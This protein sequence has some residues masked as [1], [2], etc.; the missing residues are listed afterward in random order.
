MKTKYI[1]TMTE[2]I[3]CPVTDKMR[4]ELDE[5]NSWSPTCFAQSVFWAQQSSMTHSYLI[6][7]KQ[8]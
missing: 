2:I 7:C 4:Q 6:I 1:N 3:D 8:T 5:W